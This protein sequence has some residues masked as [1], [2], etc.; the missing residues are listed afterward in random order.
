MAYDGEGESV[1]LALHSVHKW[2]HCL[3]LIRP[4]FAP[5]LPT[6]GRRSSRVPGIC[7]TAIVST[8]SKGTVHL[9]TN[10][11]LCMLLR[12]NGAGLDPAVRRASQCVFYYYFKVDICRS[13][14]HDGNSKQETLRSLV[15]PSGRIRSADVADVSWFPSL[16]LPAPLQ[17]ASL[18]VPSRGGPTEC[19]GVMID[20]S[21]FMR[22]VNQAMSTSLPYGSAF[23]SA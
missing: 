4:P 23:A 17:E 13:I 1:L 7:I 21:D 2:S 19:P 9:Y 10:H 22:R 11:G 20:R 16:P 12:F 8:R 15:A 5:C 3:N 14:P 6:V 18:P